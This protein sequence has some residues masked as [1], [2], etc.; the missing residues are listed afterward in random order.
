MAD[1]YAL[2]ESGDWTIDE[3][4][5]LM[6]EA[7]SDADGNNRLDW[8]DE[9]GIA[10]DPST[11]LPLTVGCNSFL[12]AKDEY[13]LPELTC[14]TDDSLYDVFLMLSRKLYSRNLYVY[15]TVRNEADGMNKTAMF[16]YGNTL[17]HVMTVGELADLRTMEISFGLLPVPKYFSGQPEYVSLISANH[18][19]AVG[20]LKTD[21]DLQRTSIILEN[22]CAESHRANST[23]NCYVDS[24]LSYEYIDEAR[25]RANLETV[26]STGAFELSQIYGWGGVC[27]KYIQAATSPGSYSSSLA[28]VRLKAISEVS[29]T[30]VAVNE[31]NK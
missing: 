22:L 20:V 17:F 23:R 26:L 8:E 24:V 12:S 11:I 7:D 29:D 6:D 31:N 15:D 9:Y 3:M 18:A 4:I 14:F 27:D 21:R 1:P 13:G 2:A 28:S 10:I 25:S 16:K 30:I 19:T 5:K